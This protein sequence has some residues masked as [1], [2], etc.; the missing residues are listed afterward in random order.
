MKLG[1]K[2][3]TYIFIVIAVFKFLDCN[4]QSIAFVSRLED[5]TVSPNNKGKAC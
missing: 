1:L 2:V 3:L 5:D 4:I